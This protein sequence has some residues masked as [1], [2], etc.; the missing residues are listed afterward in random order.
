MTAQIHTFPGLSHRAIA[1]QRLANDLRETAIAQ[2]PDDEL[3]IGSFL[4]A[5][6]DIARGVPDR[7]LAARTSASLRRVASMIEQCQLDAA[8]E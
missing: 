4:Q 7:H 2:A 1:A 8:R 5:T 6:F 3:I